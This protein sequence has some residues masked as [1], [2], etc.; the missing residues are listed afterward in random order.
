MNQQTSSPRTWPFYVKIRLQREVSLPG[1]RPSKQA[2]C[3]AAIRT[4]W[5]VSRWGKDIFWFGSIRWAFGSSY[6]SP[7]SAETRRTKSS[8][9]IQRSSTS[10]HEKQKYSTGGSERAINNKASTC[11][12]GYFY[13][14]PRIL[15]PTIVISAKFRG[16][17]S[18]FRSSSDKL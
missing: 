10:T 14:L 9:C 12:R 8:R 11:L 1:V 5:F 3:H 2:V 6:L 7:R 13:G 16:R 4:T 17:A 18:F 15:S